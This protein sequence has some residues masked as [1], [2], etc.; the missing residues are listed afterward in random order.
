MSSSYLLICL[1]SGVGGLAPV[2]SALFFFSF[3][4]QFCF[5]CFLSISFPFFSLS[6]CPRRRGQPGGREDLVRVNEIFSLSITAILYRKYN[7]MSY[8]IM[9]TAKFPSEP[10]GQKKGTLVLTVRICSQRDADIVRISSIEYWR[11]PSTLWAYGPLYGFYVTTVNALCEF[12][13][14]WLPVELLK[15]PVRTPNRSK[16]GA[17]LDS[18][19]KLR[20]NR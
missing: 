19:K 18:E 3:I 16:W 10:W 5:C 9:E 15:V 4:V 1:G 8:Y 20:T 17:F 11:Y 2:I 7:T 6:Y 13:N 12:G 14:C